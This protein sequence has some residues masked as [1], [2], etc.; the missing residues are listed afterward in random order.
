MGDVQ[1]AASRRHGTA[2]TE[3]AARA[4]FTGALVHV[5]SS[6][7]RLATAGWRAKAWNY[8]WIH[9]HNF[10]TGQL[11]QFSVFAVDIR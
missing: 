4:S 7:C 6:N 5:S 1:E 3:A 2:I 9:V 11:I 8:V 10:K